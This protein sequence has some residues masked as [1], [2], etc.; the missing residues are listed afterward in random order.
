MP[1]STLPVVAVVTRDGRVDL[2]LRGMRTAGGLMLVAGIVWPL[3]PRVLEMPCV[4]HAVTGIPCPLCG[5]TRS[6]TAT[7]HLRLHDA[8]AVNPAGVVAVVAAILLLLLRRPP[9]VVS[10]ARWTVPLGITLLWSC[11]LLRLLFK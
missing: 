4:F 10:V 5:M 6:V 7:I 8:L 3:H 9:R 1:R 11:Q 2:D